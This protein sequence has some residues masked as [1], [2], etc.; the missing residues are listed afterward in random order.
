[1]MLKSV[2]LFAGF[3]LA[4]GTNYFNDNDWI[5]TTNQGWPFDVCQSNSVSFS[6]ALPGIPDSKYIEYTCNNDGSVTKSNYASISADGECMDI[7]SSINYPK[8]FTNPSDL[9][10]FECDSTNNYAEVNFFGY[11]FADPASNQ[12]SA[13][14]LGKGTFKYS[15]DSCA[16]NDGL[17]FMYVIMLIDIIVYIYWNIYNICRFTCSPGVMTATTYNNPTCDSSS[18]LNVVTINEG[19]CT[20][21][22][23]TVIDFNGGV[24]TFVYATYGI[25]TIYIKCLFI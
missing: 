1:M 4:F 18:I 15:V 13:T 10:A 24:A 3:Y 2:L 11:F 9:Y 6:I 22:A 5:F 8:N 17:S 12:C 20:K 25:Y 16:S 19:T 23:D 7:Q 21:Y 14:A